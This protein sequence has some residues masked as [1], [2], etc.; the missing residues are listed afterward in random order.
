M[1]CIES[2]FESIGDEDLWVSITNLKW[3]MALTTVEAAWNA[4]GPIYILLY[5]EPSS[6]LFLPELWRVIPPLLHL[7]ARYSFNQELFPY[8]K[9]RFLERSSLTEREHPTADDHLE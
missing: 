9:V 1:N 3:A 4:S 6:I 5:P 8:D 7:R 2:H